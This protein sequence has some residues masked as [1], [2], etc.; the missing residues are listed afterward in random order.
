MIR[1]FIL[2]II[3]LTVSCSKGGGKSKSS[4]NPA[5]EV[6][7]TYIATYAYPNNLL[8]PGDGTLVVAADSLESCKNSQGVDVDHSFCPGPELAPTL[9]HLSPAGSVS[10]TVTGSENGSVDVPVLEGENFSLLPPLVLESRIT[11]VLTCDPVYVKVDHECILPGYE[12]V[13]SSYSTPTDTSVCSGTETLTRTIIG[14]QDN[15]SHTSVSASNCSDLT[16]PTPTSTYSSPAGTRTTTNTD[17]DTLSESC[18]LGSTTWNTTDITCNSENFHK[19][20]VTCVADILTPESFVYPSNNLN[21]GDGSETVSATGF[22]ACYNEQTDDYVAANLCSSPSTMPT[23]TYLSPE[24]EISIPVTGAVDGVS[25]VFV[26]E[27]ED[28]NGLS[29]VDKDALF[30]AALVC[31]D[32]YIKDGLLCRAGVKQFAMASGVNCAL[33]ADGKVKCAGENTNGQLGQGDQVNKLSPVEIPQYF[34]AKKIILGEFTTCAILSDDKVMCSGANGSGGLGFGDNT[35]RLIPEEVVAL[36]GAKDIVTSK[37]HICAIMSD[38]TVK[39]AGSNGSYRLGDGT[40][41]TRNSPIDMPGFGEV[42]SISISN[43][44]TCVIKKTEDSDNNSVWCVGGGTLGAY[45]DGAVGTFGVDYIYPQKV[46]GL[47]PAK[48]VVSGNQ[49]ICAILLDDTVKCTGWAVAGFGFSNTTVAVDVPHL[50]GVKD[51]YIT[52]QRLVPGPGQQSN[53]LVVTS[54]DEVWVAGTNWGGSLGMGDTTPRT[55]SLVQPTE[56][57]FGDLRRFYVSTTNGC[58]VTTGHRVF[59]VGQNQAG[60]LGIGITST[61]SLIPT[62]MPLID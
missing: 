47:S 43:F 4:Q 19:V 27:G 31:D 25:T 55:S 40:T 23:V 50:E 33:M 12:L 32:F 60:S 6:L 38:D 17:G 29:Q 45:G 1:F 58:M 59:C 28:F 11:S 20:G 41:V 30:E 5:P 48:K 56:F 35:R 14:C 34:G 18:S 37:Y 57:D 51:I 13:F 24:G 42:K 10:V 44:H 54:D 3:T 53:I 52:D 46:I 2:A 36:S 62:E 22:T 7:E 8:T 49:T 26:D 21:I 16:D 39:C 9:T 61:E 15:I